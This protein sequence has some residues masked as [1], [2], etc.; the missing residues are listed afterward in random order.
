MHVSGCQSPSGH[1]VSQLGTLLAEYG[2]KGTAS[3]SHETS[4]CHYSGSHCNPLP[5]VGMLAP[6]SP[7][8]PKEH[9]GATQAPLSCTRAGLLGQL[10]F[11]P[12]TARMVVAAP[13]GG[14]D[15]SHGCRKEQPPRAFPC[16]GRW[17]QQHFPRSVRSQQT[18]A[19]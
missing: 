19:V 12:P 16:C 2:K 9:K 6:H 15:Q 3:Q 13:Q 14:C 7:C 11:Q 17:C 18:V 5:A 1:G 8:L 10:E 4:L